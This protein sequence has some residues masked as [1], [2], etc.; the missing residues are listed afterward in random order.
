MCIGIPGLPEIYVEVF[1][2]S[3]DMFRRLLRILEPPWICVEGF[4]IYM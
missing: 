2:A 1:Q 3:R 4:L